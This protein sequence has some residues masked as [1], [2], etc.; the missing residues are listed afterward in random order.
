M[1]RITGVAHFTLGV[2]DIGRSLEFYCGIL[3]LDLI[4]RVGDDM[5][6]LRAGKDQ[7]VLARGNAPDARVP[8]VLHQAFIVESR[9]FDAGVAFLTECGIEIVQQD[10]R[11]G[12][13]A[14]FAG[15]SAY[16]P[17]PDGNM[18]E[19]IDL[20]ATAHRPLQAPPSS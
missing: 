11:D 7:L 9:D 20:R 8:V 5:A 1:L 17:D 12:P 6:F 10:E 4:A 14:V 2:R 15:R 3:G 19:I 16:F 18:L 13:F